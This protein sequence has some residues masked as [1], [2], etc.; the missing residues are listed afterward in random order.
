MAAYNAEKYISEAIQS[1]LDQTFTDFELIIVNDGS[2]DTTKEKIKAFDDP[3]IK[4]YENEG[5]C[6]IIFT[7][8]KLLKLAKGKYIAWLDA[9][10][11]S[12]KNRLLEQFNFMENNQ[13]YGICGSWAI[14]IDENGNKLNEIWKP[15]SNSESIKFQMFFSNN[16]ITSSVFMKNFSGERYQFSDKWT[17]G[18][19]YNFWLNIIPNYKSTNIKKALTFYRINSSGATLNGQ[20]KMDEN[21]LEIID[22]HLNNHGL[23]FN[24]IEK[25][26]HSSLVLNKYITLYKLIPYF[27]KLLL[28]FHHSIFLKEILL[29]RYTKNQ[30]RNENRNF[31]NIGEILYVTK[32]MSFRFN[33]VSFKRFALLIIENLFHLRIYKTS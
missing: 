12:T 24:E 20:N 8:N 7:R 4:Y 14:L 6:K 26:T 28:H 1:I 33:L 29:D 21:K 22:N 18:E 11:I 13:E 3:R 17:L 9:D 16:F 5:N 23:I 19:D 31:K 2:T 15:I 25:E 10:D 30:I 27:Q 32:K